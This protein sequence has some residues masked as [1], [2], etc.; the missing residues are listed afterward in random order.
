MI[1]LWLAIIMQLSPIVIGET[2]ELFREPIEEQEYVSIEYEVM[3]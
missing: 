2:V 1:P 3:C